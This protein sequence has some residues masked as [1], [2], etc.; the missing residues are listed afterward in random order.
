MAKKILVGWFDLIVK[1]A[2]SAKYAFEVFRY[3]GVAKSRAVGVGTVGFPG[4]IGYAGR[5]A[6][7]DS[8]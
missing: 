2:K 4:T 8:R 5:I 1:C 7:R 6:V 3:E